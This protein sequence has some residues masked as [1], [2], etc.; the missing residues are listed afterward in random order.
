[1]KQQNLKN[2]CINLKG[3]SPAG[4][5]ES[6][7]NLGQTNQPDR[8]VVCGEKYCEDEAKVITVRESSKKSKSYYYF[9]T[10]AW[11]PIGFTNYWTRT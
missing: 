11:T 3:S 8:V 7:K 9:N 2:M 6:G 1:M 10:G 5:V 4:E